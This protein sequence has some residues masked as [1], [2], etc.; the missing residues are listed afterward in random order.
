[1]SRP[2][3]E[4]T[5]SYTGIYL[6]VGTLVWKAPFIRKAPPDLLVLLLVIYISI[7]YIIWVLRFR[8]PEL[9][10]LGS[11]ALLESTPGKSRDRP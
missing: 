1:M 11:K 10:G 4:S 8:P 9:K 2:A 7:Y 6:V 5:F 3:R